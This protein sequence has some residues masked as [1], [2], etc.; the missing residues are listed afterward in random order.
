MG[1]R[2]LLLSHAAIQPRKTECA[3]TDLVMMVAGLGFFAASVGLVMFF[4][5]L[6]EA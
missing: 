1:A 3:M 2:Q 5:K 4:H 6:M